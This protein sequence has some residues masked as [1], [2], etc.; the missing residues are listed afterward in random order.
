EKLPAVPTADV[1]NALVGKIAGAQ[2]S[3]V[4]GSPGQPVQILLR[5]INS[6]RGGTAPMILLD[7]VQVVSTGL[8]SLDLNSIERVEVFKVLPLPPFMA[9][10][11]P[12]VLSSFFQRGASKAS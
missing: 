3:S 10:R 4:G 8:E 7:G 1:G 12:M 9:P 11:V 6:I 2:I 5:G